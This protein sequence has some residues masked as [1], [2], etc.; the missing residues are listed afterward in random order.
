MTSLGVMNWAY[1]IRELRLVAQLKQEA[2]ATQLDVSQ[3]S[4]SQW[5]RGDST[6]PK[7]IQE[8][9]HDMI[10]RLPSERN[11]QAVLASV[12]RSPNLCCLVA[13]V[14]GDVTLL[15]QSQAGQDLC[16]ILGRDD[17]GQPL[18]GKLG[19]EFDDVLIKLVRAGAFKGKVST[20]ITAVEA[21]RDGERIAGVMAHTP[22]HIEDDTWLLRTDVR[23]LSRE[24]AAQNTAL[25]RR[26]VM[27]GWDDVALARDARDLLRDL[28]LVPG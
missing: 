1:K 4:V 23:I 10:R 19:P 18:N 7:A 12:M 28:D 27:H 13:E 14:D 24:E 25:R 11:Q 15:A 16:R 26:P 22:V 20:A 6:P 17:I 8:K 5:E 21:E 9:L 3:A 2:L